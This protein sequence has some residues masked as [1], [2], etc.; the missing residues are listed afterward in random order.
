MEQHKADEPARNTGG[1]LEPHTHA[2]RR[3]H[4]GYLEWLLPLGERRNDSGVA[5]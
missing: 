1:G 3:A 2:T 4:D 5:A